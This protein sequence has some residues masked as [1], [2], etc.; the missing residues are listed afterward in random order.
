[1]GSVYLL[2]KNF[3]ETT[4]VI[5]SHAYMLLSENVMLGSVATIF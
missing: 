1:M 5:S 3:M 2:K 4:Q